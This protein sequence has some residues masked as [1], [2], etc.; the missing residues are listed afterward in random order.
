MCIVHATWVY[1]TKCGCCGQQFFLSYTVLSIPSLHLYS[2]HCSGLV[3]WSLL[4]SLDV[5]NLI[6]VLTLV[7]LEQKV[8]FHSGRPALLTAVGEAIKSVLFPLKWQCTDIPMCP[9]SLATYIQ[10]P[11]PF[12]IGIDSR[13][14]MMA[15]EFPDDVAFVDLDAN[16]M[17][18]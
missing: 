11:V 2:V 8:V 6:L 5:E 1:T 9:L 17:K 4:A 14:M 3:H 15:E 13:Y 12:I 18:W 10:A 16:A 7:L